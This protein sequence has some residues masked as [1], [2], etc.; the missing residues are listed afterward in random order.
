MLWSTIWAYNRIGELPTHTT[1]SYTKGAGQKEHVLLKSISHPE[2]GKS[3][4]QKE[5]DI[6]KAKER[7]RNDF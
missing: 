5:G 2:K 6:A 1:A 4:G 3:T 7:G